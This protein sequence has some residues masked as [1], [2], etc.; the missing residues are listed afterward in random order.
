MENKSK[1]EAFATVGRIGRP[2]RMRFRV[3][4]SPSDP[5]GCGQPPHRDNDSVE[6]LEDE[7]TAPRREYPPEMPRRVTLLIHALDAVRLRLQVE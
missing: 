3:V 2:L 6:C 4:P 1:D 5:A 7:A